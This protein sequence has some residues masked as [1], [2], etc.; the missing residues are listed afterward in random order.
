MT[1]GSTEIVRSTESADFFI[2]LTATI[3]NSD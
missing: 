3:T 1:E 2:P